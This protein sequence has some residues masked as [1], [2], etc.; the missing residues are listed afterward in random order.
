MN[1]SNWA[2][3][4]GGETKRRK[5]LGRGPG[6]GTGKTAGRGHKGRGARSGGNTPPGY[7]GGQMPLQ[8]RLPKRGFTNLTR[9]TY[10]LVKV[11]QL[12][13]FEPGA[14]VDAAV[15]TAAGLVRARRPIK[16]LAAGTLTKSLTVK[17]D[18]ASA[19]ARAAVAAAGGVVE[20]AASASASEQEG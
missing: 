6:A 12:E 15:L 2:P 14:V 1:L 16:L 13:R 10:T 18:K 17:V 4:P 7:E 19:S 9:T 3:A 5:R 8:R 11:E 20:T